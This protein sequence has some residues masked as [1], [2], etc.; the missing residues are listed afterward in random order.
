MNYLDCPARFSLT[1]AFA[2]VSNWNKND[3]EVID[4]AICPWVL[5]GFF[6]HS[7]PQDPKYQRLAQ[8]TKDFL[9]FH[10]KN[11]EKPVDVYKM[12]L[13]QS[14][15]T[16]FPGRPVGL[17]YVIQRQEWMFRGQPKTKR[18]KEEM[19]SSDVEEEAPDKDSKKKRNI[20]KIIKIKKATK[21]K[22]PKN[23]KN[24]NKAKKRGKNVAQA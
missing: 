1:K 14:N 15:L 5:K 18:K 2:K 21:P 24:A 10:L 16:R 6:R 22:K 11:G 20:P 4:P 8:E 9:D 13:N 12:Y 7:H 19:T 17:N 3:P 23:P